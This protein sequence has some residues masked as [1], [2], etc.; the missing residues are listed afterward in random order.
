MLSTFP[1]PVVRR[2]VD[3]VNGIPS[4]VS[5]LNLAAIRKLLDDW[6]DE[7]WQD[8]KAREKQAMKRLPEAPRDPQMEHRISEGFKELT[9]QLKRGVGP[10]TAG[11]KS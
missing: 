8:T 6:A 11:L 10:S 4:K 2:A 7:H 3:P 9:Q 1:M 5:F